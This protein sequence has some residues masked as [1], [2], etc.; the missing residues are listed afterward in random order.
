MAEKQVI[1]IVPDERPDIENHEKCKDC[2]SLCCTH[3][4]IPLF[5]GPDIVEFVRAHG[6]AVVVHGQHRPPS[7]VLEMPCQHRIEGGGCAIYE[8]RYPTC[9]RY[10]PEPICEKDWMPSGGPPPSGILLP[11]GSIGWLLDT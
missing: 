4:R 9:R 11:A 7:A 5:G 6:I 8:K 2:P 1:E 3:V 10:S